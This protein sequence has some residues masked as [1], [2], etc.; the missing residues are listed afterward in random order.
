M[1]L[2][3]NCVLLKISFVQVS[4]SEA[5]KRQTTYYSWKGSSKRVGPARVRII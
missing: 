4:Q 3:Q 2:S 1:R 5:S